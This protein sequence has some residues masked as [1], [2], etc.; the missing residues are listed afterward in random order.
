MNR[1]QW[2]ACSS[3]AGL[4]LLPSG[5]RAAYAQPAVEK[6]APLKITDVKAILTQ[7]SSGSL[8]GKVLNPHPDDLDR[9]LVPRERD[10]EMVALLDGVRILKSGRLRG[11]YPQA[12]HAREDNAVVR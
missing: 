12:G 8:C 10:E 7:P 3:A 5:A 6:L 9:D 11:R 2:L 4:P 1:R